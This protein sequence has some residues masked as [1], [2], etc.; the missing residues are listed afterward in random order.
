MSG[1]M[2][3]NVEQICC[4]SAGHIRNAGRSNEASERLPRWENV[5]PRIL[6]ARHRVRPHQGVRKQPCSITGARETEAAN[7]PFV[8]RS[9]CS[10]SGT[11]Q[12]LM[13]CLDGSDVTRVVPQRKAKTCFF[14]SH[15]T[16]TMAAIPHG[17]CRSA[18]TCGNQNELS[19]R[20]CQIPD[21]SHEGGRCRVW[22]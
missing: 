8:E 3:G 1:L 14:G 9:A 2:S 16:H 22:R 7:A 15:F 5:A 18:T 11:C 19:L 17:N 6:V 10:C 21:P 4:S 20:V 13:V 12:M